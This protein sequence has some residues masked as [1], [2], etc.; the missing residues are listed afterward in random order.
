[1]YRWSNTVSVAQHHT[2][3]LETLDEVKLIHNLPGTMSNWY[4]KKKEKKIFSLSVCAWKIGEAKARVSQRA[5]SKNETKYRFDLFITLMDMCSSSVVFYYYILSFFVEA[6]LSFGTNLYGKKKVNCWPKQKKIEL[7]EREQLREKKLWEWGRTM[8]AVRGRIMWNFDTISLCFRVF[9]WVFRLFSMHR[10]F[11]VFW[12]IFLHHVFLLHFFF[13]FIKV[14]SERTLLTVVLSRCS[15][16]SHTLIL[17]TVCWLVFPILSCR[18][19]VLSFICVERNARRT[20]Q[21]E[22]TADRKM[23]FDEED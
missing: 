3:E 2:D 18:S 21:N 10:R 9:S 7:N 20:H 23:Y 8:R 13:K 12:T 6:F 14:E 22:Q 4:A 17:F 5:A 1:M 15:C 19:A 11:L 16:F